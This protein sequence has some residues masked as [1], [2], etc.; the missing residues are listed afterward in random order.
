MWDDPSSDAWPRIECPTLIVPAAAL[1]DEAQSEFA[2]ARN[3]LVDLAAAAI[4]D[5]RVR[6]IPDTIHDIGYHKP[7]ELARAIVEFVDG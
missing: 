4:P 7:E 1:P 3:R 6:W 2:L 5:C